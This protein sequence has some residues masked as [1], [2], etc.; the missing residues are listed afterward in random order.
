[1][2]IHR[3]VFIYVFLLFLHQV[4]YCWT[5]SYKQILKLDNFFENQNE[6]VF[7]KKNTSLFTQLIFSW[8]A[9]RP[10]RGYL[11]FYV[12][13]HTYRGGWSDF[14]HMLDWGN[15]VQKSY[16]H[17]HDNKPSFYHVRLEMHGDNFADAFRIKIKAHEGAVLADL[18]LLS[19]SI[20]DFSKFKPEYYRKI[21]YK[22][23]LIKAVPK[24]S[25][26]AL[27]H[28]D[29]SRI[30]SPTSIT[31]LLGYLSKKDF[32]PIKV[33]KGSF[34]DGLGVYGS[35]PFNVAHAFELFPQYNFR[36]LRLRSFMDIYLSLKKH[37]PVIVSI[38]GPINGGAKPYES[39]HLIIVVGWDNKTKSVIVH[40]PAFEKHKKVIKK[41]RI[42]D[43]L[44]AWEKS[45][46]LAYIV[47]IN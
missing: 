24:I 47:E 25:Q 46:R 27:N 34:D 41:Y 20:S 39:G 2:R 23:I 28:E 35:W 12:Q 14:Y 6:I 45:N 15:G 32:D 5:W 31:M 38:R 40:D 4:S 11:S 22:S 13:V 9:L 7:E 18:R 16:L 30:C 33:S 10:K 43:F 37:L 17:K 8:N 1:M 3:I 21:N 42:K 19:V 29:S 36:V 26:F 44:K